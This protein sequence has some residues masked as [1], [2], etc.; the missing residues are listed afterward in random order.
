MC[1]H[2]FGVKCFF[3]SLSIY[4]TLFPLNNYRSFSPTDPSLYRMIMF[5]EL[6]NLISF[7]SVGQRSCS[8]SP[9][10]QK[11]F[12]PQPS[13]LIGRLP[14]MSKGRCYFEVK[15]SV[16]CKNVFSAQ[17]LEFCFTW[18]QQPA[19]FIE[20]LPRSCF[21][22]SV[23]PECK[24]GYKFSCISPITFK[25]HRKIAVIEQ[26]NPFVFELIQRWR[27]LWPGFA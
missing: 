7:R 9:G 23:V 16:G 4:H 22:V 27:S 6:K 2:S 20:W 15:V 13:N 26:K 12:H 21:W 5:S 8:L 19:Y 11:A 18:H 24:N 10:M 17:F 1:P 14:L 25:L 3:L